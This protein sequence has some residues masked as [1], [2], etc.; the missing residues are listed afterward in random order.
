MAVTVPA[1]V[2]QE[3]VLSVDKGIVN[4]NDSIKID[5]KAMPGLDLWMSRKQLVNASQG[6]VRV[7]LQVQDNSPNQGWTNLDTL[8]FTENFPAM[9]FEFGVY[10]IHRGLLLIHDY[11]MNEGYEI[12]FNSNSPKIATPLS[13]SEGTRLR[14]ILREK[15]DNFR[16]AFRVQL[17]QTLWLDGTQDTKLPIGI[18]AMIPIANTAGSYGGILRSDTR[19]Q[20]FAFTGMTYVANGTMRVQMNNAM[21]QCRL[22]SRGSKRGTY[23]LLVGRAFATNYAQ[24]ATNNNWQV[25]TL[26]D[27]TPN[28]D[29]SI[30]DSGLQFLG[31]PLEIN[32]TFAILDALYAPAN[33]WDLRCYFVHED[34]VVLGYVTSSAEK[35]SVPPDPAE[36]RMT[37]GSLDWRVS[38]FITNPN[39]CA[40]VTSVA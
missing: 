2:F 27:G 29:I 19:I 35:F 17:D 36:Q 24:Y 25:H 26:A 14:D 12:D 8:I 11:L 9:G 13:K 20:N 15:L 38:P 10:N 1:A 18:D 34:S 6:I 30:A 37:R 7:N 5:R 3:L 28:L 22:N 33:P 39:T 40:V 32:P 4:R 21:Y 23:R 31:M 16:D